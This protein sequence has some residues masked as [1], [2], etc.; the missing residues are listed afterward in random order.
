MNTVFMINK[1]ACRVWSSWVAFPNTV[2]S[3]ADNIGLKKA[4]FT[5]KCRESKDIPYSDFTK[6]TSLF[7]HQKKR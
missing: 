3:D 5:I 2:L 4:M 6:T 1:P 7:I